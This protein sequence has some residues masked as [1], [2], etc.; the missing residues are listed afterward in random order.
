MSG[1]WKHPN[2][3][4]LVGI[5]VMACSLVSSHRLWGLWLTTMNPHESRFNR[6]DGNISH[7]HWEM[8]EHTEELEDCAE[9]VFAGSSFWDD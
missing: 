6:L 4:P 1:G 8:G 9:G 2:R 7:K 5:E 3:Q